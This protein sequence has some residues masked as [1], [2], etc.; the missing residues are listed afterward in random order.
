MVICSY[1]A[2]LFN[3]GAAIG[4]IVLADRLGEMPFRAAQRENLPE[5]TSLGVTSSEL[6]EHYGMGLVWK[7]V[8]WHCEFIGINRIQSRP[9]LF[10]CLR[11]HLHLRWY[12]MHNDTS[13]SLCMSGRAE[14]GY[15]CNFG[16]PRIFCPSTT[17]TLYVM[18]PGPS[19]LKEDRGERFHY[20]INAVKFPRRILFYR[21]EHIGV[22]KMHPG[23]CRM[24]LYH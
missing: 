1:G 16:L 22:L 20:H 15:H 6:L 2:V 17:R 9:N 11:G 19:N 13:H 24:Y 8:F 14:Q 21:V 7:L 3:S 4:S 5:S 12:H 23:S 18:T 10:R